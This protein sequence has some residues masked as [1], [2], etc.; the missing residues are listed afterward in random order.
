MVIPSLI[1]GY[2]IND[3]RLGKLKFKVKKVTVDQDSAL[4]MMNTGNEAK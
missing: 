2:L 3:V 4:S 1:T